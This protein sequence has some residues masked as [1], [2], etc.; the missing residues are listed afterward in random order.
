MPSSASQ[1]HFISVAWNG[2]EEESWCE[3]HTDEDDMTMYLLCLP[4]AVVGLSVAIAPI[5][6][7]LRSD[8]R[9]MR[10]APAASSEKASTE[11]S[12]E[13]ERVEQLVYAA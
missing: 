11:L 1:W 6:I 4:F 9:S 12:T 13:G 10:A 7:G 2:R 8:A 5:V 3:G